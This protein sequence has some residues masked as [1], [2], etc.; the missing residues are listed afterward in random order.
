[1]KL[2]LLG[3]A[4]L[5]GICASQSVAAQDFDDR[6]YISGTAGYL[7]PDDDRFSND[8]FLWG[9]GF[10][11]RVTENFSIDLEYTSSSLGTDVSQSDQ[12]FFN[13]DIGDLDVETIELIGRYHFVSDGRTWNPYIAFGLGSESD[14]INYSNQ[15]TGDSFSADDTGWMG[16]LG[17]GLESAHMKRADFRVEAGLRYV[18]EIDVGPIA[19][20]I[21]EVSFC[22]APNA[23]GVMDYYATASLLVKLGNLPVPVVAAPITCDTQDSDGDGVNDCN[24]KC[25]GSAAGQTIGADGCPVKLTIDLKGVNF[26]FD[27]DTLRPDAVVILDE[28]VAVLAK[29][30]ELRVEVAGHTDSKGTD[31]YNQ[32]LS[33]RRAKT[34]FDY[35][36]SKGI[37]A[38]RMVGPNGYGES[39][40]IDTNDT[41]EGRANNRRTE[42]NVQN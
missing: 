30:P 16:R 21:G 14:T 3:L 39:R 34:V 38:G 22:L 41:E 35:L 42:L 36:A 32:D 17:F 12:D 11:K 8:D 18:D 24:D 6:W 25:P 29:Y 10:G 23:S 37:D 33:Q 15:T 2:K 9:V 31:E 20:N 4:V 13:V 7:W 26:D 19:C 40:P 1:M 28:A 27:K 5:S